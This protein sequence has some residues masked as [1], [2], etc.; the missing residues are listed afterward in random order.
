[1]GANSK[2]QETK[3]ARRHAAREMCDT[4]PAVL[5]ARGRTGVT[6]TAYETTSAARTRGLTR[7]GQLMRWYLYWCSV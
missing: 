2:K 3:D 7:D 4:V 6:C 5:Q 1:M